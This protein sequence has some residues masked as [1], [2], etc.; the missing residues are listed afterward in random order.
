MSAF[1]VDPKTVNRIVGYLAGQLRRGEYFGR[2]LE[3]ELNRAEFSVDDRDNQS[4]L[5]LAM[6][7]LNIHAVAQR[8]PGDTI[9]TLPGTYENGVLAP[10]Q[11][12]RLDGVTS[13]GAYK[14]IQCLLYQ[15]SEGNVPESAL[16]KAL[17]S[18]KGKVAAHIVESLP[19]YEKAVWE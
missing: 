1:V 4:N 3:K 14:A 7:N 5:G 13:I 18:I 19:E 12:D 17:K 8:Y 2:T 16:Y 9:Q 6:Y 10:Y 11:F 15:M